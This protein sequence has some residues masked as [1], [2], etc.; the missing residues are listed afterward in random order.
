M[1]F[2]A[3]G[4]TTIVLYLDFTIQF[5]LFWLIQNDNFYKEMKSNLFLYKRNILR[6]IFCYI[7]SVFI[8]EIRIIDS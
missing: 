5:L 6:Y 1:I 7:S 8:I 2:D 4:T 3:K